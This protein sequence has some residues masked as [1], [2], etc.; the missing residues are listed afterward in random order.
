M[1]GNRKWSVY[2]LSTLSDE[3]AEHEVKRTILCAGHVNIEQVYSLR[4]RVRAELNG[5]EDDCLEMKTIADILGRDSN[6]RSIVL[7]TIGMIFI[8]RMIQLIFTHLTLVYFKATKVIDWKNT[9]PLCYHLMGLK[10]YVHPCLSTY[11]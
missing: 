8:V 9:H 6:H 10:Q 7:M 2:L 11:R 4:E 1:A 5:K 3:E